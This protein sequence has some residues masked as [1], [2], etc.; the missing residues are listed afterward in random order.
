MALLTEKERS[1]L[2]THTWPGKEEH[3][4][5]KHFISATKTYTFNLPVAVTGHHKG[6]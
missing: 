3:V 2:K 1:R 6:T 5:V 4:E